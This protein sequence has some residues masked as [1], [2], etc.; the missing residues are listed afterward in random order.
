MKKIICLLLAAPLLSAPAIAG[1]K[2]ETAAQSEEAT[3][4]TDPNEVVCEYR[5]PTGSRIREKICRTRAEAEE[6]TRLNRHMLERGSGSVGRTMA[7][8]NG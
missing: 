5:R 6:E 7:S 2:E 1:E 8:P 3:K 4:K